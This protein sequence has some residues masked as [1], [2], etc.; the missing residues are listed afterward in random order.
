L[1]WRYGD[2][3]LGR[4]ASRRPKQPLHDRVL[5]FAEDNWID[6]TIRTAL[7]VPAL[8]VAVR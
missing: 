3:R 1:L 8:A 6:G 2:H 5:L 4:L 7:K